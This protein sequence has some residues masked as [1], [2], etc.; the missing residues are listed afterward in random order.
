MMLQ[1]CQ[2]TMKTDQIA[3]R[4]TELSIVKFQICPYAGKHLKEFRVSRD[5]IILHLPHLAKLLLHRKSDVTRPE[6]F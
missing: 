5:V 4:V 1:A 6:G 2:L 3:F